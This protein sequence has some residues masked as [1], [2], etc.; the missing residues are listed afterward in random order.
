MSDKHKQQSR[1]TVVST[2]PSKFWR[3]ATKHGRKTN[4]H[5]HWTWNSEN[6]WAQPLNLKFF[7]QVKWKTEYPWVVY[8]SAKNILQCELCIKAK[9]HN[10]FTDTQHKTRLTNMLVWFPPVVWKWPPT[11]LPKGLLL[12]PYFLKMNPFYCE[13]NGFL[14]P[15]PCSFL[16]WTPANSVECLKVRH[17]TW[18]VL[19]KWTSQKI[20]Y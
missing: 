13:V 9:K 14:N 11:L 2:D 8:D 3:H 1:D 15:F 12:T 16:D 20:S 6:K 18:I 10:T 4:R 5:S 17:L 7:F 19:I